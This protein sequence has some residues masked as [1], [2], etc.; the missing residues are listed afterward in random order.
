MIVKSVLACAG[1][2]V[3]GEKR[4]C[5]KCN[6]NT[7][8][9]EGKM[10]SIINE[11]VELT[12]ATTTLKDNVV[13]LYREACDCGAQIKHRNG[14]N[15]HA[16]HRLHL[17]GD[18]NSIYCVILEKTTSRESFIGDQHEVLVF[19]DGK[20]HIESDEHMAEMHQVRFRQGEA[21]I[22]YQN[23]KEFV[24]TRKSRAEELAETARA[25]GHED[26]SWQDFLL[27]V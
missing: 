10:K 27:D 2:L 6:N 15:Y 11:C 9:E 5:E 17:I 21:E 24:K 22:V 20:F 7:N 19:K 25:F 4:E 1:C 18:E 12:R 3:F 8:K 14:G 13:E 16:I 26:A 23:P